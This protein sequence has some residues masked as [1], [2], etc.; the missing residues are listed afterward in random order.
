LW[1]AAAAS[2]VLLCT[3]LPAPLRCAIAV[4]TWRSVLHLVPARLDYG[5]DVTLRCDDSHGWFLVG[6]SRCGSLRLRRAARVP[7][8]G[9]LLEFVDESGPLWLRVAPRALDRGSARLLACRLTAERT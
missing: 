6:G 1:A 3:V 5:R 4:A 8:V 9:W 2:F 7:W